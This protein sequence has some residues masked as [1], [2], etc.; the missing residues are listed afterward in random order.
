MGFT[1]N[2]RTASWNLELTRQHKNFDGF[3]KPRRRTCF[4]Q[5]SFQKFQWQSL[6][7]RNTEESNKF[8]P[9]EFLGF[10][11]WKVEMAS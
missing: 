10:V 5:T 2:S 1:W 4:Q 7:K 3:E 8:F 9:R 11:C 6:T